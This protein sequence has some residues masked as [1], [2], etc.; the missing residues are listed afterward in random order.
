MRF[1]VVVEGRVDRR[2]VQRFDVQDP[3]A[4]RPKLRQ[5]R[6]RHDGGDGAGR[7]RLDGEAGAYQ[8][9]A[10]L[11]VA[12]RQRDPV[13][14]RG[15]LHGGAGGASRPNR[16][17]PS[18]RATT[19]TGLPFRRVVLLTSCSRLFRI[20]Y[21]HSTTDWQQAWSGPETWLR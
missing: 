4:G 5:L 8:R 19:A 11:A 15:R 18:T 20:E 21:D 17:S 3:V 10:G 1:G 14:A 2:E 7:T 9:R 13:E 12:R 16:S 6:G